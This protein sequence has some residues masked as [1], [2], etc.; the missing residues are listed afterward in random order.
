M[1]L[2]G[3]I[4][5]VI[6]FLSYKPPPPEPQAIKLNIPRRTPPDAAGTIAPVDLP[7]D[8]MRAFAIK[9]P[10]TLP[11]GAIHDGDTY[12]VLFPTGAAHKRALYRA[13]GTFISDE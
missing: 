12:I 9:Y 1:L 3:V 4:N 6:G 13:D 2:I 5:L 8:V 11:S 10:R 7:A